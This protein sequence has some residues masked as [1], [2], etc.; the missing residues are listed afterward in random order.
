MD[1]LNYV[2]GYNKVN[3]DKNEKISNDKLEKLYKECLFD[4]VLLDKNLRELKKLTLICK[5]YDIIDF[6]KDTYLIP[7]RIKNIK[8][9]YNIIKNLLVCILLFLVILLFVLIIIF[10]R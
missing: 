3:K 8:L 7:N 10:R 9:F 4:G 6:L 1:F 5:K 2:L